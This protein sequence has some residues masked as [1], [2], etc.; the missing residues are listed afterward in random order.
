M[1][2]ALILGGK[3]GFGLKV[4][5]RLKEYYDVTALGSDDIN[6]FT[7]VDN[8][9]DDY[10]NIFFN[11]NRGF[12]EFN[13]MA[14]WAD[15]HVAEKFN[16]P[17]MPNPPKLENKENSALYIN[18][19]LP[20]DIVRKQTKL[21]KVGW[22]IT[23]DATQPPFEHEF[24]SL[25]AGHQAYVA[26][27]RINIGIALTYSQKYNTFC[28]TPAKLTDIEVERLVRH[29]ISDDVKPWLQLWDRG[30]ADYNNDSGS[31]L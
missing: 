12:N 11:H 10:D 4:A 7:T 22:M 13:D 25:D 23:Y 6:D 18:C 30:N 16:T 1:D 26:L 21:R 15:L 31:G 29:I 2:K 3:S 14:P 28:V 19:L 20:Y 9:S 27:K 24:L 5:E 17:F 8:L